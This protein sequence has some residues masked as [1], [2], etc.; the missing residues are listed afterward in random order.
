MLMMEN[1]QIKVAG[2][3]ISDWRKINKK[4][5]LPFETDFYFIFIELLNEESLP[6]GANGNNW[7]C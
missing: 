4:D 2:P 6:G 1:P 5:H 7:E 3:R